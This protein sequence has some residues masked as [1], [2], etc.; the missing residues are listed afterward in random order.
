MALTQLLPL[1]RDIFVCPG[2]AVRG[3]R[4]VVHAKEFVADGAAGH[5]DDHGSWFHT[6]QNCGVD[7]VV[8]LFGQHS[9]HNEGITPGGSFSQF[10]QFDA[11]LTGAS[12]GCF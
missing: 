6:V 1:P 3:E 8:G 5:V 10:H 9:H 4:Y 11:Q 12:G 7:D 2:E